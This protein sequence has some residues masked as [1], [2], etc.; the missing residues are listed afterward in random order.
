MREGTVRIFRLLEPAEQLVAGAD[1]GNGVSWAACPL[2]SRKYKDVPLV[3]HS[4]VESPEFGE[5]LFNV[6]IYVLKKTG[7]FPLLAIE[8]N[9][10]QATIFKVVE[11][12]WPTEKLYRQ[13][14]FDRILQKEEERIGFVTSR[15]NRRKMLDE[16]ALKVKRNEL[17]IYDEKIV[18]EMLTFVINERTNEPRP[19]S[20]T[21]SDLIMALAIGNQMLNESWVQAVWAPQPKPQNDR[22]IPHRAEGFIVEH[23]GP[24]KDWR[25]A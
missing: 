14:T 1:P 9:I 19:E 6:G 12:G 25:N 2:I 16:L 7:S 8:R 21:F 4:R 23:P 18:T 24:P 3:Y 10:G 17:K 15:S 11:L 20:G 5:D 13:K 22:F